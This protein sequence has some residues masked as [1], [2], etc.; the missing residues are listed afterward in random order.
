MGAAFM[1]LAVLDLQLDVT[2]SASGKLLI[3]QALLQALA[4]A[5]IALA[6]YQRRGWVAA[7]A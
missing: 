3:A 7:H 2:P 5:A 4:L 6:S 1:V